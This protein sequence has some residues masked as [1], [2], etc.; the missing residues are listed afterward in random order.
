MQ[1]PE[2]DSLNEEKID[3]LIKILHPI[4]VNKTAPLIDALKLLK[5]QLSIAKSPFFARNMKL[6]SLEEF[7]EKL[8][9]M[10]PN[11]LGISKYPKGRCETF[12]T[13]FSALAEPFL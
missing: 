2:I 12:R 5:I 9:L 3:L 6:T 13:V 11:S 8:H 10:I 7:E 1:P 4:S